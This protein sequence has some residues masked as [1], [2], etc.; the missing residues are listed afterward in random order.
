V[1]KNSEEEVIKGSPYQILN[2]NQYCSVA[3]IN[4]FFKHLAM[5]ILA[6]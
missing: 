6:S 3:A 4:I 1:K 5:A 2:E